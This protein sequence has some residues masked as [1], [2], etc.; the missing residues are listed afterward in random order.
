[1]KKQTKQLVHEKKPLL[2]VD[3]NLVPLTETEMKNIEGG[4]GSWWSRFYQSWRIRNW[5]A[6]HKAAHPQDTFYA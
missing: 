2:K 5:Y 4:W 6:H 1:M 3:G